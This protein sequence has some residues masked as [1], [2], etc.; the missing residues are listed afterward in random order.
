MHQMKGIRDINI[1]KIMSIQIPNQREPTRKDCHMISALE[2]RL[3]SE[4]QQNRRIAVTTSTIHLSSSSLQTRPHQSS[5]ITCLHSI[6]FRI[7]QISQLWIYTILMTL[8]DQCRCP[9]HPI[10]RSQ[11]IILAM[12][13][14]DKILAV[15]MQL[16]QT[17][18]L[19]GTRTVLSYNRMPRTL[20]Q[21]CRIITLR[22][23]MAGLLTEATK[24]DRII[25][26]RCSTRVCMWTV[27][28]ERRE[29]SRI[30]RREKLRR[31]SLS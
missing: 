18:R 14:V 1:Y 17:L 11:P 3:I 24:D 5:P 22:Q 26:K 2:D 12:I 29:K 19:K 27:C 16:M 15:S 25:A 8:P 9:M 20:Q 31:K 10:F 13:S 23:F 21:Q 7:S 28:S 4:Q 6:R 30:P